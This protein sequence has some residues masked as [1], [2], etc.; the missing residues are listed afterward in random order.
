MGQAAQREAAKAA[1][2]SIEDRVI[3]LTQDDDDDE[4]EVVV[5]EEAASSKSQ[6]QVSVKECTHHNHHTEPHSKRRRSPSAAGGRSSSR[7]SMNRRKAQKKVITPPPSPAVYANPGHTPSKGLGDDG[8]WSCPRCTLVNGAL[9]LQCAACMLIR[10]E[11]HHPTSG[12]RCESCGESGMP[13]QFW[14]CRQ[15]GSIKANSVLG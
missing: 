5:L 10:P 15:C 14:S 9:A 3:D 1:R 13:H 4:P 12:W 6:I 8:P 7:A 2:D 11:S